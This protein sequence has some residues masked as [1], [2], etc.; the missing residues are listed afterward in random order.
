M[1]MILAL[2]GCSNDMDTA[3]DTGGPRSVTYVTEPCTSF[4]DPYSNGG[5]AATG[6]R[7]EV[8]TTEPPL[9]VQLCQLS[10]PAESQTWAAYWSCSGSDVRWA[11]YPEDDA[12]VVRCDKNRDY[13]I[14]TLPK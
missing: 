11:W 1:I 12:V 5:E 6:Y 8:S 3:A 9:S 14:V 13:V 7:A 2:L 4:V 10:E